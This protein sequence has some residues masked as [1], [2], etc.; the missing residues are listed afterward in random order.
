MQSY[1]LTAKSWRK[2]SERSVCA[3]DLIKFIRDLGP[4]KDEYMS[5]TEVIG[6]L[7]ESKKNLRGLDKVLFDSCKN[8]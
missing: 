7:E 8:N 3:N 4:L 1:M 6:R 5:M 2:K